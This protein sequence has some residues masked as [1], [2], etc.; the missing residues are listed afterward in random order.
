M[1]CG[2]WAVLRIF[3]V[4][5]GFGWVGFGFEVLWQGLLEVEGIGYLGRVVMKYDGKM[6][7]RVCWYDGYEV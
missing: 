1:R 4:L 7:V 3:F 6:V 5:W 2:V